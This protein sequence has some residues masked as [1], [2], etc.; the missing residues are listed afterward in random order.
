MNLG[1]PENLKLSATVNSFRILETIARLGPG[2]TAKD[3]TDTLS[4]P[5]TTAY[6]LLNALVGDEF[7]VRT[8]DLRGF[9]LGHAVTGFISA[10]ALP[11]I[12]TAARNLLEEFRGQTRFAVHLVTF[13]M[14]SIKIADSDP[15]HPP[16]SEA[17][18]MRYL[19]A[20]AAGKLFLSTRENPTAALPE[21]LLK[22]LTPKTIT[23]VKSLQSDLEQINKRDYAIQLDELEEGRCCLAVP[24]A[25]PGSPPGGALCLGGTSERLDAIRAH[26]TSAQQAAARLAPLLF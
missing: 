10:G 8:P 20:S 9:T 18:M 23:D 12:P 13:Q 22:K 3:I 25:T 24:I 19:H 17:E 11:S 26:L 21:N 2:T 1:K 6:R 15:D 7:L 16:R 4:M 5:P 14:S